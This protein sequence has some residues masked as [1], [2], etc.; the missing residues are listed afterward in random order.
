MI[1]RI[2]CILFQIIIDALFE[3][4]AEADLLVIFDAAKPLKPGILFDLLL[5]AAVYVEFKS[6]GHM[7]A[8]K[9]YVGQMNA[10]YLRQ[11]YF[12]GEFVVGYH[13]TI[14]LAECFS[15]FNISLNFLL[16]DRINYVY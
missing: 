8:D 14:L 2:F 6:R 5:T 3:L 13:E 4:V 10:F 7:H 16:A 15:A 12:Y 9:E 11:I 1:R